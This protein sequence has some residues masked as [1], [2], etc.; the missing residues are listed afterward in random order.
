VKVYI[1]KWAL[2]QGILEE[3]ANGTS[4]KGMVRVGKPHQTR[5]YHRG[6]YHETRAQAVSKACNVRDRKIEDVKKQLAK[7]TALTFE[8]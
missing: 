7:L 3:E 5:Y 6:E 8:E 4:V 1:T 2:T